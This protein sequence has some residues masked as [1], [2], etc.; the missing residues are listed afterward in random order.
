VTPLAVNLPG[1]PDNISTGSDGRIWT[2]MVTPA[3]PTADWLVQRAP[4]VRKLLWRLPERLQPQIPSEIWVV[5]F[6]PDSGEVVGGLRTKDPNFGMVTGVVE[7]A[8]KLWM[9]CIGA[10]AIAHTML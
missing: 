1:M 8:G 10:P 4:V 3:N 5:G 6:D 2:A 7:S 9:A